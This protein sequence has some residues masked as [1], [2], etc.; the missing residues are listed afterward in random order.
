MPA[1]HISGQFRRSSVAKLVHSLHKRVRLVQAEGPRT[2]LAIE[3]RRVTG[4]TQ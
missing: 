2:A 4:Y 1:G 3:M